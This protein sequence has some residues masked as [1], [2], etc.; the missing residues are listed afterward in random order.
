[1]PKISENLY[2]DDLRGAGALSI[3]LGASGA[4]VCVDGGVF[5][6]PLTMRLLG[7]RLVSLA[8]D[9]EARAIYGD[10]NVRPDRS[11]QNIDNSGEA[12]C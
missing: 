10:P 2:A 3:V 9:F 8:N 4:S 6:S 1:M 11:G 12:P 5:L 7:R